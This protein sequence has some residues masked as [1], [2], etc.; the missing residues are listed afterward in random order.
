MSRRFRR[1]HRKPTCTH[2]LYG[3][4]HQRKGLSSL[5]S[6][7]TAGTGETFV[8]DLKRE[9]GVDCVPLVWEV[10]R[11]QLQTLLTAPIS[12]MLSAQSSE[13]RGCGGEACAALGLARVCRQSELEGAWAEEPGILPGWRGWGWILQ[14]LSLQ[15]LS[16]TPLYIPSTIIGKA[17][18]IA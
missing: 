11:R 12:A 2:A 18:E 14:P 3:L 15:I 6:T 16:P 17:C 8:K 4:K 13:L 7:Q 10:G 9:P 1:L 5:E